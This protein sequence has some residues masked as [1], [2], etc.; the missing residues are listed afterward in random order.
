MNTAEEAAVRYEPKVMKSLLLSLGHHWSR[1]ET[2]DQQV[3]LLSRH[4]CQDEMRSALKDL[5]S[6]NQ[7]AI[8]C[9]DCHQD[10][11]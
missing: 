2:I 4:F 9:K 3:E 6:C 8:R 10:P 5:R 1:R 7:T 11:G